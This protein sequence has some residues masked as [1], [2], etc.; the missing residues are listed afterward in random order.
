MLRLRI[1][2]L[3]HSSLF[4]ASCVHFL[5]G[6]SKFGQRHAITCGTF[7]FILGDPFFLPYGTEVPA[8]GGS[9]AREGVDVGDGDEATPGAATGEGG[10][11][12]AASAGGDVGG[13]DEEIPEVATGEGS[14]GDDAMQEAFAAFEKG[15]EALNLGEELSQVSVKRE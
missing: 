1:L 15:R 12:D 10:E 3:V 11:G 2:Q 4:L 8:K 7:S 5:L 13:G 9:E 6:R 14:D